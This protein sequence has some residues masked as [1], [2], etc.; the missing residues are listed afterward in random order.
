MKQVKLNDN[1]NRLLDEISDKRKEGDELNS[2]KQSIIHEL[3]L[4]Q[5]KKE[6]KK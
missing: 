3:V 5:H 4:A 6:L 1:V 2:S